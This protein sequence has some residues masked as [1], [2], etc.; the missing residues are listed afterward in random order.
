ML[1][2]LSVIQRDVSHRILKAIAIFGFTIAAAQ[3]SAFGIE[4]KCGYD[5]SGRTHIR[6]R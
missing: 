1:I 4:E 6:L 2:A 5:A 3:W